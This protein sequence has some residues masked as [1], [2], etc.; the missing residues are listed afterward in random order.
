MKDEIFSEL[1]RKMD[2]ALEVLSKDFSRIRTGRAS[3][4]LLEGIKVECYGTNMPINQV[5]SLAAPESRLLTIQPWD[6]GILS[7]LEKAILKSDLGLTPSNDGK[8]IRIPIPPLT[9]ERR[10]ELVKT[11]KKMAEESKVALRNLRREANE[12][13]KELKK[14]KLI[15]EDEAFKAQDEVQKITDN[16]IKKVEAQA[17]DKEKEI[18]SF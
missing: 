5:A 2:R 3:V 11:T 9:T 1:R 12:Q 18:M 16:Y 17:E 13:L 6:P 10:K 15:S 7:D 8:I 14:E 4:S